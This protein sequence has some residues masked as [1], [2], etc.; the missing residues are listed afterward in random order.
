MVIPLPVSLPAGA[1]A[2]VEVEEEVEEVEAAEAAV[3]VVVVAVAEEEEV[4]VELLPKLVWVRAAAEVA[5]AVELV[6]LHHL[7]LLQLLNFRQLQA[8]PK[9]F[10][11]YS[12]L[13]SVMHPAFLYVSISL[14]FRAH[15]ESV[16]SQL[17][18]AHHHLVR[19]D[20]LKHHFRRARS[21]PAA[22]RTN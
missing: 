4:V 7:S 12:C 19:R 14:P 20:R 2:A 11:L 17:P 18:F 15:S 8:S 5:A 1:A 6:L 22:V 3:V 10:F 21:S 16:P 9:L 13:E